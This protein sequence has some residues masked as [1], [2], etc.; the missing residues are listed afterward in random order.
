MRTGFILR[1]T[2][3]IRDDMSSLVDPGM[4]LN[5]TAPSEQACTQKRTEILHMLKFLEQD[6]SK[7]GTNKKIG[8]SFLASY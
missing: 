4:I 7:M 5:L 1:F 3:A 8:I 2:F 6:E